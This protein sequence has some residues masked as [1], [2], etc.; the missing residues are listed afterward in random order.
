MSWWFYLVIQ[1]TFVHIFYYFFLHMQK[2]I[3]S[4]YCFDCFIYL[5]V[6][7]QKFIIIY[8]NDIFLLML[9]HVYQFLKQQ[10]VFV[11]FFK[12]FNRFFQHSLCLFIL[13]IFILYNILQ[14]IICYD[15]CDSKNLIIVHNSLIL[16]QS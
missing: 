11:D 2:V 9:W 14:F 6:F 3:W 16:L 4:E 8:L 10:Q 5:T 15:H 13:E 12:F 1:I 7:F